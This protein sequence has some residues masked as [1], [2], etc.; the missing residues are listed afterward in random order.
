TARVIANRMWERLF[1]VGIVKTSDDFGSQGEPPVNQPLLDWLA[2]ELQQPT[3]TPSVSGVPARP[4]DL[5]AFQEVLVVSDAYCQSSVANMA[6]LER[7]P[8]NRLLARGPRFRLTAEMI[9]DQ[10]LA[11]SGLL[12]ERIG[13]P[14]VRPYQ[15]QGVWEELIMVGENQYKRD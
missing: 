4:W 6:L 15:P 1:G 14:S 11:V 5:K 10:A 9:R 12:V 13:G 7:D 8:E 3:V 2:C